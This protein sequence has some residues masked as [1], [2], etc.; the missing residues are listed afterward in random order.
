MSTE[1]ENN[2]EQLSDCTDQMTGHYSQT[3][4]RKVSGGWLYRTRTFFYTRD[5]DETPIS[6]SEALEFVSNNAKED[7]DA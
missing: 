1:I 3:M 2:W 5:E 4:R 7:P 6:V